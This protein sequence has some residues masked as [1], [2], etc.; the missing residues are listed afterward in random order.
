[1]STSARAIRIFTW[2]AMAGIGYSWAHWDV[3]AAWRYLDYDM[4]SGRPFSELSLNGPQLA[5]AYRW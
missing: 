5:V 2:Q 1:M 3:V 4:G